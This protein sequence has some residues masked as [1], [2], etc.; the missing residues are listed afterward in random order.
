MP[1]DAILSLSSMQRS[2]DVPK[3]LS[4]SLY[5]SCN[6][7]YH[8]RYHNCKRQKKRRKINGSPEDPPSLMKQTHWTKLFC[9]LDAIHQAF[10]HFLLPAI[11]VAI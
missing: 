1:S 2:V 8:V 9:F 6:I 10:L 3:A 7:I 5:M 4:P 11:I